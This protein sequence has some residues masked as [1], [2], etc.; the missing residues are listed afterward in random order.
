MQQNHPFAGMS[1]EE[2]IQQLPRTRDEVCHDVAGDEL[3]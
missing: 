1:Q 3:R 2:I